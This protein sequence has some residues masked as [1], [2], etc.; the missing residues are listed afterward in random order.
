MTKKTLFKKIL[1]M[2]VVL[3]LAFVCFT[4]CRNSTQIIGETEFIEIEVDN[5]EE[6]GE[7]SYTAPLKIDDE[8]KIKE[9]TDIVNGA[10]KY[11]EDEFMTF[12]SCPIVTFYL[13]DGSNIKVVASDYKGIFYISKKW[14]F[15]DKELYN[16]DPDI[17]LASYIQE[18]YEQNK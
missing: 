9:L 2:T 16:I 1:A 11:T 5:S 12:E 8:D 4:G 7:L 14:D 3:L 17:K 18:L 6:T 15:S 13:T 10:E